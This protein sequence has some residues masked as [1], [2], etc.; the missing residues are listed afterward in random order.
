MSMTKL[1]TESLI[2]TN[3]DFA[4]LSLF[5]IEGYRLWKDYMETEF[6]GYSLNSDDMTLNPTTAPVQS[7]KKVYAALTQESQEESEE[8]KELE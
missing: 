6:K 8:T 1:V 5:P 2:Y 4:K 3:H 7:F